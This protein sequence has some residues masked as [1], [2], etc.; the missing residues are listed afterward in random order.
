LLGQANSDSSSTK[1]DSQQQSRSSSSTTP[2]LQQGLLEG[3]LHPEAISGFLSL[4]VKAGLASTDLRRLV[5]L[6]QQ[7][8]C[9]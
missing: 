5:Q 3:L 2:G 7:S 8:Y 4:G 6:Q 1:P 9:M